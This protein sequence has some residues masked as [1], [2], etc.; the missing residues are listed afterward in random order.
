MDRQG[1][2]FYLPGDVSGLDTDDLRLCSAAAPAYVV[3]RR[4]NTRISPRQRQR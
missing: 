3:L 2:A 1:A 4:E